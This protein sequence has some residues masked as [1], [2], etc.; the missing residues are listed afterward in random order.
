MDSFFCQINDPSDPPPSTPQSSVE[1]LEIDHK[2]WT[3]RSP[4]VIS[5]LPWLL[6]CN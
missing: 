4:E 5:R 6:P 3:L 1:T 2:G